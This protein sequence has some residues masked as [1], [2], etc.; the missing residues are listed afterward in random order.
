[1]QKGQFKETGMRN[2]F[3]SFWNN[4]SGATAIEYAAIA[5]FLSVA[6]L[7]AVQAL[8]LNVHDLYADITTALNA[9]H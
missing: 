5:M 2:F 6:L 3:D 7:L 4:R 9:E 8:S 1:L